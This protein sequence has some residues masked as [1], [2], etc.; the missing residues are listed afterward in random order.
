[1][2]SALIDQTSSKLSKTIRPES[3]V[4]WIGDP[5]G[6]SE[7]VEQTTREPDNTRGEPDALPAP[8]QLASGMR[9]RITVA[10]RIPGLRRDRISGSVRWR[11]SILK[12]RFTPI[13][14]AEGTIEDHAA[15]RCPLSSAGAHVGFRTS[16]SQSCL[17]S[18]LL[19]HRCFE[20]SQRTEERL[21]ADS[22][23]E[24]YVRCRTRCPR[25]S[26]G[27]AAGVMDRA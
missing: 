19:E 20:R 14:R 6:A 21:I 12:V 15:D 1:V 7:V 8:E 16:P 10:T 18:S 25:L 22:F 24:D 3:E 27:V 26:R 2:P 5:V 13:P 23:G 17:S 9:V 4:R 11:Q